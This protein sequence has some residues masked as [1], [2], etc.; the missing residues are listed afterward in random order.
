MKSMNLPG[1]GCRRLGDNAD[2]VE[3]KLAANSLRVPMMA[4]MRMSGCH[5]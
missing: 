3:S 2:M 1:P 4:V 5:Y